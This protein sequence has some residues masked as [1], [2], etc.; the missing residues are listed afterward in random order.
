MSTEKNTPWEISPHPWPEQIGCCPLI[1]RPYSIHGADWHNVAAATTIEIAR[2][3][4]AAPDLKAFAEKVR[5][6]AREID[7]DGLYQAAD[8]VIA[9]ADGAS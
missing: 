1:G 9:K 8:S 3:I 2:L 7:D 4:A 6:F 5:D